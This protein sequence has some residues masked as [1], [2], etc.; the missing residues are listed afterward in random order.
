MAFELDSAHLEE[1]D[2]L[3]SAS[4]LWMSAL[5]TTA[6]VLSFVV[7]DSDLVP[8]GGW[9]ARFGTKLFRQRTERMLSNFPSALVEAGGWSSPQDAFAV[10]QGRYLESVVQVLKC[11]R[12]GGYRPQIE[13]VGLEHLRKALT[14]GRGAILWSPEFTFQSAVAKM[15]LHGEGFPVTFLIRPSHPFS[16]T[17]AGIRFLNPIQGRIEERY[18]RERV[19]ITRNHELTAI[20]SLQRRLRE[21]GVVWI[22]A[23]GPASTV[24]P[25]PFL[26]GYLGVAAG[27]PR[28]ARVAGCDLLPLLVLRTS[29]GRFEVRIERPLSLAGKD[30]PR[31]AESACRQF[32]ELTEA[33]VRRYPDQWYGWQRGWTKSTNA[34]AG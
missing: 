3:I 16:G 12:P 6:F 18:V 10:Q 33:Y 20:R 19:I 28:L 13:T 27:P 31:V 25:T 21:N 9:L 29:P 14:T 2:R 7:P 30:G 26:G 23:G 24:V 17:R 32:S 11:Y 34:S 8:V 1:G 4:D 15:A 22:G 5:L